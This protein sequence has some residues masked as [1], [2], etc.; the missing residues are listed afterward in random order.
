MSSNSDSNEIINPRTGQGYYA[1]SV[2]DIKNQVRILALRGGRAQPATLSDD[3][4]YYYMDL[5]EQHIDSGLQE[6]YMV[7]IR[8]YNHK[9]PNGETVLTF[10]SMIKILAQKFT[11]A[12]ILEAEFQN[13][14]PNV[15]GDLGD[16][17]L[18]EC[19]QQLHRLTS[20]NVRVIGQTIKSGWGRTAIP[21][22]QPGLPPEPSW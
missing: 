22:M 6:L 2:T 16:R 5:A 10:P 21:S 18:T 13:I 19:K 11:A 1:Q 4:I 15:A 9:M 14:D 3:M 17:Y 20:Y 12:L 8:P 7:P